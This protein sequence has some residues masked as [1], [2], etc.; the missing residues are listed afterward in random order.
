MITLRE[1]TT[2]NFWDIVSLEVDATQ[3]E[4][5][6][7]NAVSIAQSKVQP[8]CIPLAIYDGDTPVGFVMYCIDRDDG[9]YWLYRMMVDKQ[10]QSKGYGSAALNMVL[11]IIDKD[12]SRGK[13][14]LGVHKDSK[15]AVHIYER[16]GFC[17][18]GEVYGSEHIMVR[19]RE[20]GAVICK[21]LTMRDIELSLFEGF[22]RYQEV[23]RCW[24]KE[25]GEWLLKDIAFTEQWD[26]EDYIFLVNCLRNT[27]KTGGAVIGA[28]CGDSLAGFTS[29]EKELFGSSKQY[30][31]LS[32]I[33]VT[34]E[35]RG[36]GLGKR[37]FNMACEAAK[38][39]GAKKLYIS[40]HS[41]EES[42]AF[43]RAMGCTEAQEYSTKLAEQEPC[44]CQLEYMLS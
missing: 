1:I 24:R 32:C 37:L 40:A 39:L 25:A 6:V 18:N 34:Y 31:Q 35:L 43:Y 15:A 14:L 41:S 3:Q 10:Y 29:V 4:Y 13:V 30:L 20:P 12:I 28:F 21:R 5:V 27:L 44:D 8:E 2:E 33:H 7:S 22:N 9:E 11:D 16:A 19:K 36:S 26:E 17:F 23:K 42:Q 38:E